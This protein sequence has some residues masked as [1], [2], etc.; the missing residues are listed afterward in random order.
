MDAVQKP[1]TAPSQCCWIKREALSL[2]EG[3]PDVCLWEEKWTEMFQ[4]P[5]LV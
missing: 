1:P 5:K 3:R 4:C 2:E